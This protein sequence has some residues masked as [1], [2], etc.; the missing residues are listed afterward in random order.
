MSGLKFISLSFNLKLDE[1]TVSPL[2][3]LQLHLR[4][5]LSL[6]PHPKSPWSFSFGPTLILFCPKY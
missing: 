4:V 5:S 2:I 3:K 1:L 6:T